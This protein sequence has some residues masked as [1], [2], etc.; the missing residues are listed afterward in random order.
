MKKNGPSGKSIFGKMMGFMERGG[1]EKASPSKYS[2]GGLGRWMFKKMMGAKKVPTLAEFR[3]MAL[4]LGVKMYAC[5][6]SMDVMEI[7]KEILIDGVTDSVGVG[8]MI[9]QAQESVT[10]LFI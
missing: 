5:Q 3:Q 8:F 10:T 4:D 9:E 1:L 7:P 6:M 2:M